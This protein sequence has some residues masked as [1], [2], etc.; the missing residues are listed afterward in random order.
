MWS[1]LAIIVLCLYTFLANVILLNLLITLMG[2]LYATIKKEQQLVFLRNRADLILEVREFGSSG[3][4]WALAVVF[5]VCMGRV[6]DQVT[7]KE[8]QLVFLR[9]RADL[10]VEVCGATRL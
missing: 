9:N 10:T 1:H 6:V 7:I 5:Y 3:V 4:L 8:Q 2:D